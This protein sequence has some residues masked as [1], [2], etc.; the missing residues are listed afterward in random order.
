[1]SNL[2]TYKSFVEFLLLSIFQIINFF[3]ILLFFSFTPLFYCIPF[4]SRRFWTSDLDPYLAAFTEAGQK[5][6]PVEWAQPDDEKAETTDRNDSSKESATNEGVAPGTLFYS[7]LVQVTDS[8]KFK[9]LLFNLFFFYLIS[10]VCVYSSTIIKTICLRK[11]TTIAPH[12]HTSCTTSG[13]EL[14]GDS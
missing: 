13:A 5:V 14:N 11:L 8:A 2:S 4:V 9:L 7:F 3:F 10:I 1:L 6:V 12:T